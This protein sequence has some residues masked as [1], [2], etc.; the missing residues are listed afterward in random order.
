M[1]SILS[2]IMLMT[3]ISMIVCIC[4]MMTLVTFKSVVWFDVL[5]ARNIH[6]GLDDRDVR[7]AMMPSI[8]EASAVFIWRWRL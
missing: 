3:V 5:D 8:T 6:D 7:V 1:I 2:L 4:C